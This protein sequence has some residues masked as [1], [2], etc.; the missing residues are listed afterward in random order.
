MSENPYLEPSAA[1]SAESHTT[2]VLDPSGEQV[3]IG[4]TS[5]LLAL[6]PNG[7]ILQERHVRVRANDGRLIDP[8]EQVYQCLCGCKT[9]LLTRH[10]VLFCA[11]CQA[12]ILLAH[13]R[14]WDDGITHER[15]CP[16]CWEPKHLQRALLRWCRWLTQL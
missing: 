15:V 8:Q 6:N 7:R 4:G 10:S 5:I 13:A 1:T 16:A 3:A 2:E 14:S 11:F 9:P 12:P